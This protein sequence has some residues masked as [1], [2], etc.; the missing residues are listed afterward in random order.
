MHDRPTAVVTS[1]VTLDQTCWGQR[2]PSPLYVMT[3]YIRHA[4]GWDMLA[5]SET[6]GVRY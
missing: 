3:V 5:H 4:D 6:P 2:A 1:K